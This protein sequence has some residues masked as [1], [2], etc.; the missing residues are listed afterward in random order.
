MCSHHKM[1]NRCEILQKIITNLQRNRRYAVL[2]LIYLS[3]ID[4][5]F[6][7]KLCV[8]FPFDFIIEANIQVLLR[9]FIKKFS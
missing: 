5:F 2:A 9:T 3:F 6:I 4:L 8:L 1:H 7:I